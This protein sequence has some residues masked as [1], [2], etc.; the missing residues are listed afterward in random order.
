MGSK[1]YIVCARREV[2]VAGGLHFVKKMVGG[3]LIARKEGEIFSE[4]R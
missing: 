1:M 3:V 4:I 2:F